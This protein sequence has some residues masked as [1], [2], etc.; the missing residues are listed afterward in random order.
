MLQSKQ[1]TC[2]KCK[3][4]LN[5]KNL[6][7]R[8]VKVVTCPVC[9]V[10]LRVKFAAVET[11]VSDLPDYR[12]VLGQQE[13]VAPADASTV[14]GPQEPVATSP[15]CFV[16]R[17]QEPNGAKHY[18]LRVG[19]ATYPLVDGVNTIGRS[20]KSDAVS[21]HIATESLKI[22]RCHARIELVR[23]S[24]GTAAM[25]ISNW[26]NKNATRVNGVELKADERRTVKPG[27]QIRMGDVQMT[28]EE[29]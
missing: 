13:P 23:N 18:R 22:S 6:K 17:P 21:I 27:D 28:L 20:A 2:P 1:I 8:P 4:V 10:K 12:T 25:T 11:P 5:V 26:E 15:A 29:C 9:G 14:L 24:D 16:S 19:N 3:A 7:N